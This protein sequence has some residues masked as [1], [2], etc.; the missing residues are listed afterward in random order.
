MNHVKNCWATSLQWIKFR[1]TVSHLVKWK[2]LISIV[3]ISEGNKFPKTKPLH[4][5]FE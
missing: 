5:L 2:Y 3:L 1:K 4:T